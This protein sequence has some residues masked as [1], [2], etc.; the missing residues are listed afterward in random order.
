MG[1]LPG[2]AEP[3]VPEPGPGEVRIKQT[4]IGLNFI[5]AYMRSGLYPQDRLPFIPGT[6]G[7]GVITALGEGVRTLLL[8]PQGRPFDQAF[9]RDLAAAA[10]GFVLVCGRYEGIDERVAEFLATEELSLGDFVL[11]GG[12]VA[13]LAVVEALYRSAREGKQVDVARIR[14]EKSNK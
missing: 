14:L 4:A 10:D 7:A 5:D 3:A 12:E 13:A 2:I 1:P 11:T 9:A 8:S 6:E